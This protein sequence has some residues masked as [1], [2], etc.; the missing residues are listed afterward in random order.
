MPFF[1]TNILFS[2]LFTPIFL[3]PIIFNPYI[4]HRNFVQYI[5]TTDGSVCIPIDVTNK[6]PVFDGQT[7]GSS[8]H[9]TASIVKCSLLHT[10]Q[11]ALQDMGDLFSCFDNA[12]A[13]ISNGTALGSMASWT[14]VGPAL[15][16][17]MASTGNLCSFS[18]AIQ[19]G[20]ACGNSASSSDVC[21][22]LKISTTSQPIDTCTTSL[23]ARTRCAQSSITVAVY[24][25]L[26]SSKTISCPSTTLNS[27]PTLGYANSYTSASLSTAFNASNPDLCGGDYL[28]GKTVLGSSCLAV[29]ISLCQQTDGGSSY[30]VKASS[31]SSW[32]PT[33][34][35]Q[36]VNSFSIPG[37]W[38]GPTVLQGDTNNNFTRN[39]LAKTCSPWPLS[40][41]LDTAKGG[42]LLPPLVRRLFGFVN[43]YT[44]SSSTSL[45][46]YFLDSTIGVY[47]TTN[48]FVTVNDVAAAE[49]VVLGS[50]P[51]AIYWSTNLVYCESTLQ[52]SFVVPHFIAGQCYHSTYSLSLSLSDTL[53]FA[54]GCQQLCDTYATSL[55]NAFAYMDKIEMVFCLVAIALYML[56][57]RKE[58]RD[59][60]MGLNEVFTRA[61]TTS[62]T[63]PSE[64][65]F[66]R[67]GDE[68]DDAGGDGGGGGKRDPDDPKAIFNQERSSKRKLVI[69]KSRGGVVFGRASK[70]DL[71]EEKSLNGPEASGLKT[72]RPD[73]RTLNRITALE[74]QVEALVL[75]LR[76]QGV[77]VPA[78]TTFDK[79]EEGDLEEEEEGHVLET[80][81]EEPMLEK[82]EEE[83]ED[84]EGEDEGEE[85]EGED[86]GEEGKEKQEGEE[87]HEEEEKETS[88]A[89]A[90]NGEEEEQKAEGAE[91]Q[92]KGEGED[93]GPHYHPKN[94]GEGE[95]EGDEKGAQEHPPLSSEEAKGS[96]RPPSA[97]PTPAQASR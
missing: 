28:S 35:I 47:Y 86:E 20:L 2:P 65:K 15:Q 7:S 19:S 58:A 26:S 23:A 85:H 67:Q 32:A 43:Y 12:Y 21:W 76:Q 64:F 72:A 39:D 1:N 60:R 94:E 95:D 89:A 51:L 5:D 73:A 87:G 22:T 81:L 80:L 16:T 8:L 10:Q 50:S 56:T 37:L 9:S 83:E 79:D 93:E 31:S 70:G 30:C 45:R 74:R 57:F 46:S 34:G 62:D 33:I 97:K 82:S 17:L 52:Y 42:L 29:D 84:E 66:Q 78:A 63:P 41:P 90:A 88:A 92:V 4:H 11:C 44:L 77:E 68:K 3:N 53:F 24:E 40:L 59:L 38:F 36:T 61:L 55:G 6:F 48:N 75:L 91:D 54:S 18:T 13:I 25:T 14:A 27:R 69:E 49:R 96:S 71:V